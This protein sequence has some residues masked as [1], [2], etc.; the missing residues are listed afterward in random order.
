MALLSNPA[1]TARAAG[2]VIKGMQFTKKSD[3]DDFLK[4]V[5]DEVKI[6]EVPTTA[7]PFPSSKP[8]AAA[9]AAPKKG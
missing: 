5:K 3:A 1:T 6:V 9:N 7:N 4:K 8:K 2:K